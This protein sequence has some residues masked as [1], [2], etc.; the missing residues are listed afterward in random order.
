MKTFNWKIAVFAGTLV[1]VLCA[2]PYAATRQK[3][4]TALESARKELR[5]R[6]AT[7]EQIALELAKLKKIRECV[8]GYC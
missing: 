4:E 5:I 2:T 3:I 1:L 6:M 7:E 8:A